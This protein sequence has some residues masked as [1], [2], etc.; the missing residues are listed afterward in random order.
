MTAPLTDAAK[1]ALVRDF[2][3]MVRSPLNVDLMEMMMRQ[4]NATR[5]LLTTLL[6]RAPT[7]D[8]VE[9]ARGG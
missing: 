5:A 7:D 2:G 9:Q 1:I 8:E 3:K 4:R 6:G